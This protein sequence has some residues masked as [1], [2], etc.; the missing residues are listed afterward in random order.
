MWFT[1]H[2][3][4]GMENCN[5]LKHQVADEVMIAV[6]G[7][8]ARKKLQQSIAMVRAKMGTTLGILSVLTFKLKYTALK[9]A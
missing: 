1:N 3:D 6:K 2:R 8:T 5:F 7:R 9:A 4:A